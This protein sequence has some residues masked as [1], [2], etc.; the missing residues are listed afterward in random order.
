MFTIAV[1]PPN[2]STGNLHAKHAVRSYDHSIFSNYI[3]ITETHAADN[4]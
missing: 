2:I 3:Q 4:L 1:I